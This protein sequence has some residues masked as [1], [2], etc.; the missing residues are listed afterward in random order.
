MDPAWDEYRRR[1]RAFWLAIPLSLLWLAPGSL[2]C[3][4]LVRCGLRY[5]LAFLFAIA[6]S[7]LGNILIAHLKC[8]FWPCPRCGRPF[9]TT[10]CY[11]SWFARRCIHCGLPKWAPSKAIEGANPP[12]P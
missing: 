12:S 5:D 6:L 7:M 4:F 11:G 10:W 9:H 1:R 2:L 8:M 3:Y